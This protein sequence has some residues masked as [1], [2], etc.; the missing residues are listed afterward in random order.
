MKLEIRD[1]AIYTV[2]FFPKI[3][4]IDYLETEYGNNI[5]WIPPVDKTIK[6]NENE[7]EN[8]R[9][10]LD[11]A[12]HMPVRDSGIGPDGTYW[13]LSSNMYQEVRYSIWTPEIDTEERGY[14]DLLALQAYLAKLGETK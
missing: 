1:Y 13:I 4:E 11:K 7:F 2:P 12:L 9:D 6:I 10:L 5:G 8:I 14:T 3:L